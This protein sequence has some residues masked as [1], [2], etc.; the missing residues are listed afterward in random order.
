MQ[1]AKQGPPLVLLLLLLL[2]GRNCQ[3]GLGPQHLSLSCC[4]ALAE[5][6]TPGH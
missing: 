6:A 5:W 3:P 2:L 1:P 4:V